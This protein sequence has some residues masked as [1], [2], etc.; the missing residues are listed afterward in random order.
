M[1]ELQ[2][3]PVGQAPESEQQE[4][5][6]F[7]SVNDVA[8][9]AGRYE[10]ITEVDAA[11]NLG[12][13]VDP[14]IDMVYPLNRGNGLDEG[15]ID[16]PGPW[17]ARHYPDGSGVVESSKGGNLYGVRTADGMIIGNEAAH[18]WFP[19][20]SEYR[21]ETEQE[22]YEVDV[23]DYDWFVQIPFRFVGETLTEFTDLD[24]ADEDSLLRRG[25]A[26]ETFVEGPEFM[27][28]VVGADKLDDP[29]ERGV[30]LTHKTGVQ[31][32]VGRDSTSWDD[33]ELFGFVPFDGENGVPAPS[34][35]DALDLLRPNEAAVA[36][37]SAVE[38]QGEWFL[39]PTEDDP[40]GTIQ[41]PG[42]ASKEWRYGTDRVG[43]FETRHDAIGAVAKEAGA[44]WI[45]LVEPERV[46]PSGSPLDNHLP[47]DW[48]TGVDDDTFASR[49]WRYSGGVWDIDLFPSAPQDVLDY[50]FENEGEFNDPQEVYAD[51]REMAE[52]IYV[53]G[54]LRHRDNEHGM[55]QADDWRRATTHEWDVMTQDGETYHLE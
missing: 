3:E 51:I 8:G 50:I 29:E 40:E 32:Y 17:Q 33:F 39:V 20:Q 46:Y 53:R 15:V 52:G 44:R 2:E 21:Q 25:S 41:K 1:A 38:R 16:N 11:G 42:V 28:G 37:E 27:R 19:Y 10:I 30:L 12:K 54:T 22:G 34:A 49:V 45:D 43:R 23:Y 36:D 9:I 6:Q 26:E 7:L 18:L 31:V 14:W 47:R 13:M 4:D 35:E 48:K 24:T 55:V 5:E